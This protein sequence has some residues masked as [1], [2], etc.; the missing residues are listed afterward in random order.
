MGQS[1]S[2]YFLSLGVELI[3]IILLLNIQMH[4]LIAMEKCCISTSFSS[5]VSVMSVQIARVF[6]LISANVYFSIF[7][8]VIKNIRFDN[9]S[10]KNVQID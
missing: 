1:F 5:K 4:S 3:G 10:Y 6:F 7:E 8:S 9:L 2:I